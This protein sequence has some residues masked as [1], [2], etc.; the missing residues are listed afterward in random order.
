[1]NPERSNL[2]FL[3]P[4]SYSKSLF[5]TPATDKTANI[6]EIIVKTKG[7]TALSASVKSP[8][9][10]CVKKIS[11]NDEITVA[12]EDFIANPINSAIKLM[13][14]IETDFTISCT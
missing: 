8:T 6:R 3:V 4:F 7:N 5:S 12:F 9:L 2:Y 10:A 13:V 1:M 11:R 14:T